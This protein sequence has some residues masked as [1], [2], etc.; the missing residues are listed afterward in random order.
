V[1]HKLQKPRK[2]FDSAKHRAL[3][4]ELEEF[5]QHTHGGRGRGGVGKTKALLTTQVPKPLTNSEKTELLGK[6]HVHTQQP[7]QGNANTQQLSKRQQQTE[8][9]PK[10]KADSLAFR[11][12][13]KQA[14]LVSQMEEKSK[15]TG[16]PLHQLLS[17]NMSSGG[18]SGGA[19][20]QTHSAASSIPADYMQ[21]PSCGRHFSQKAGE[22]HIPQCKNIINKPKHYIRNN[23]NA[24]S[25]QSVSG[26]SS[27]TSKPSSST[28]FG[29]GSGG[30]FGGGFGGGSSGRDSYLQTNSKQSPFMDASNDNN[31]GDSSLSNARRKQATGASVKP[32]A[33]TQRTTRKQPSKDFVFDDSPSNSND[34]VVASKHP[35]S[36]SS[37]SIK[38][39]ATTAVRKAKEPSRDFAFDDDNHSSYSNTN[40]PNANTHSTNKQ[41]S[42]S[43][44]GR[45]GSN[46]S[47]AGLGSLVEDIQHLPSAQQPS[48]QRA[49][50]NA[51]AQSQS[52]AAPPRPTSGNNRPPRGGAMQSHSNDEVMESRSSRPA[53]N[54]QVSHQDRDR[55]MDVS[56]TRDN[57]NMNRF[58]AMPA[59]SRQSGAGGPVVSA[60]S[61][62]ASAPDAIFPTSKKQP[63]P[64]HQQQSQRTTNRDARR[65]DDVGSYDDNEYD[66][67]SARNHRGRHERNNN[68][69]RERPTHDRSEYHDHRESHVDDG[70]R[71]YDHGSGRS[72]RGQGRHVEDNTDYS[73]DRNGYDTNEPRI[74][75]RQQQLQDQRYDRDRG[76]QQDQQLR[77][78]RPR[79]D[80]Y[81][82]P[83]SFQQHQQSRPRQSQEPVPQ[84][85]R[86]QQRPPQQDSFQSGRAGSASAV[87]TGGGYQA[88][89]AYIDNSTANYNDQYEPA[90]GSN[91]RS[92]GSDFNASSNSYG[93]A[94]IAHYGSGSYA[95]PQPTNQ[96]PTASRPLSSG[97]RRTLQHSNDSSGMAGL[98]SG[99]TGGEDVRRR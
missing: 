71:N 86:Y 20:G 99:G 78:D 57:R 11:E 61:N 82:E 87:R 34:Y 62:V 27:G 56:T 29:G 93:A 33:N 88:L 92:G 69:A 30:G 65:N 64:Q 63:P 76:Y 40:N 81:E 74:A 47:S 44:S 70:G 97:G 4:T 8:A 89:G 31:F 50:R 21:C 26:A 7:T 14:K 80:D 23:S 10:W 58:E 32:S 60:T 46:S 91:R 55:D 83:P 41:A 53:A 77:N 28:S 17:T 19:Y 59:S 9:M 5:N 49:N 37:N 98:L 22:R 94:N 96:K 38:G 35:N 24:A 6:P 3:G 25:T 18:G 12:A 68:K 15:K 48:H 54:R 90:S 79:Q 85:E 2:V 45:R 67:D 42:S 72:Y 36:N 73:R 39:N 16:I 13:M 84:Q 1:C 66:N 51:N 95:P 75:H 52:T 43:V